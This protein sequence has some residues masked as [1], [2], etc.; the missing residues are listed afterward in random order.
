MKKITLVVSAYNEEKRL[1]KCLDSVKGLVEEVIV[2]DNSSTDTTAQIAE[3]HGA[4][5]F[6]RENN[7]MLNVNKNF[8]FSKASHEWIL[9]LDADESVT[10]ELE[11]EIKEL[12][13]KDITENGFLIPRKNIIFG[14]WIQNSIWWP[15]YQLRLFRKGKGKFAEKHIHELLEVE[16]SVGTLQSPIEHDNYSSVSQWIHKM[17]RIYTESEAEAYINSGK[18]ITWIDAIRFPVDDFLKTFFLQK[19]YKDGLHGLVLSLLQA[20]YA[21]IT[22]AKIWE[23]QGFPEENNPNFLQSVHKESKRVAAE[24]SYW[25]AT[26]FIADKKNKISRLPLQIRRKLYN[27]KK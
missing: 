18:K 19:G 3:K 24:F 22:F 26:E 23:K 8:G 12:L 17:D 6:K 21:E 15:D 11:N 2:I 14:K 5:V 7:L 1:G 27:T 10:P 9:N 16:G 20:F 4:K 13:S 25:F